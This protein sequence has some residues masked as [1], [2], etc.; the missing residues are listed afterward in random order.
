[1]P[2]ITDIKLWY[3][4]TL[5]QLAVARQDLAQQQQVVSDLEQKIKSFE[6]LLALEGVLSE[7]T[8]M[9]YGDTNDT[10]VATVEEALY[11]NGTALHLSEIREALNKDGVPI[12]GKGTDANLISRLQRSNGRIVR[13]GRGIYDVPRSFNQAYLVFPDDRRIKLGAVNHVGRSDENE[14]ILADSQVSRR[15]AVI[16]VVDNSHIFIKDTGT[17]NGTFVNGCR[18]DECEIY[19]GDVIVIGETTLGIEIT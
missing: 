19:N 16:E 11:K 10:L 17:M 6:Q 7:D 1:M 9:T 12:P 2:D 15:H 14:I 18:V 3:E 4:E 13:V 8:E 5:A